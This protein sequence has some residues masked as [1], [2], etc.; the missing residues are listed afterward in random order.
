M[1][2]DR[3]KL[4]KLVEFMEES[5][6]EIEKKAPTPGK[7]IIR[8]KVFEPLLG[9]LK[10]ITDETR[11]PVMMMVGRT[12]HGKS[13]LIN[14]IS[15]KNYAEIDDVRSCTEE[16]KTYTIHFPEQ[17]A[18]MR[19]IDTRGIFESVSPDGAVKDDAID[20]LESEIIAFKP[21]L[22]F[23]VINAKE[24]RALQKD[25]EAFKS[26]KKAIKKKLKY[27]IPTL[28]VI[29][30]VDILG[31][32]SEWPIEDF[33]EKADKI[34]Q[35]L[36][37]LAE[38][39]LEIES[40]RFIDR[41]NPIK[42]YWVEDDSYI[43]IIPVCSEEG[44]FWNIDFLI[45]FIGKTLPEEALLDFFQARGELA[46]LKVYSSKIIKSFSVAA[47]GIGMTP[48]P[49]SDMSILLPIQVLMITIIAALSG[50]EVSKETAAEFFG[51]IGIN[52]GAAYVFKMGAQQAVK[53]LPIPGA[54]QTISGT[55][56]GSATYGIGKSAEA[57]FF[58]NTIQRPETFNKEYNLT[59]K[60]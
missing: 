57:Y 29:S 28:I 7:K 49:V 13:S 55:I 42:G 47:S 48:I 8:K 46:Q 58:H 41:N 40:K 10:K 45:D 26:I 12:G 4:S 9:D 27:E 17:Y 60:K 56:A 1:P 6:N 19:F 52:I 11:P 51:A 34:R 5:F 59:N 43:G 14:A 18:S 36:D 35:L 16:A 31:K 25:I 37:F 24:V 38:D 21:D 50:R 2:I 23:H 20:V 44:K 22:L 39:V 30:H 3:N 54:A 33:P 53:L 32:S 15:G